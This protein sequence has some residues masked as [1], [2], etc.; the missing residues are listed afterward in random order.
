M[1]AR[2]PCSQDGAYQLGKVVCKIFHLQVLL[3][4][5]IFR[6]EI[7]PVPGASRA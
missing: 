3:L 2:R 4:R 7:E 6:L 5:A 1:R